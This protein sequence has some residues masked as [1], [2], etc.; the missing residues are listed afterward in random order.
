VSSRHGRLRAGYTL[1]FTGAHLAID[2]GFLACQQQSLARSR[3]H[4]LP[5]L[6][7][8]RWPGSG[9]L[10]HECTAAYAVATSQMPTLKAVSP[11]TARTSW[12]R[13]S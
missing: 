7:N 10:W 13:R 9:R 4:K 11:V 12:L 3:L 6:Y 8:G 1:S 2:V 5:A